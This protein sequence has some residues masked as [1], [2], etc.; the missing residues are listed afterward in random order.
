MLS[1]LG[2]LL[3]AGACTPILQ[4]T[5]LDT[6]TEAT[7]TA[8]SARSIQDLMERQIDPA[9]DVL[10]DSVAYIAN[11]SGIEERQPRTE[12]QWSAVRRSALLL[13]AATK[14]LATPGLQVTSRRTPPGPGEL[15]AGEIARRI[16]VSRAAFEQLAQ[17]LRAAGLEAV[18]AIDARDA[19]RLMGAGGAIDA[20]CEACH[21][22]YW[23]PEQRR[24]ES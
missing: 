23:Y 12:E 4:A 10:W 22:T 3:A 17:A 18:A 13:V 6:G 11:E 2:P 5:R 14:L 9:A 21:M 20:A 15:P 16:R 19:E 7:P 8:Q 24:P 1:C